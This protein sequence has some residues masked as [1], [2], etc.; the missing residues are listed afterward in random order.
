MTPLGNI[1]RHHCAP[2]RWN[3][4][5][6]RAHPHPTARLDARVARPELHGAPDRHRGRGGGGH[7][8]GLCGPF[9]ETSGRHARRP[10]GCV[11]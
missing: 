7:L 10:E 6:E 4:S 11:L 3:G 5:R 1:K 2:G 9:P 8:R